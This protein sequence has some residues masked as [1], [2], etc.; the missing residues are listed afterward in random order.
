VP[1]GIAARRPGDVAVSYADA[2]LAA[3]LLGW[4]AVRDLDAMC[5]DAWRWQEWQV[6]NA[7]LL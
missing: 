5:R 1:F 4:K 2:A 3:R 7:A 6:A